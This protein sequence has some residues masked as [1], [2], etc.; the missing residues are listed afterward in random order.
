MRCGAPAERASQSRVASLALPIAVGLV[1]ESVLSLVALATLSRVS[2]AAVAAAGAVSYLFA[3]L[4]ALS[5]VFMNGVMVL[6]SQALGARREGVASRVIGETL[7]FSTA[8]SLLVVCSSPLWLEGY[9]WVVSRGN[10][11][12]V[13]VGLRYAAARIL[14][15]PAT[16]VGSVL[17]AAYRCGGRPWPAALSSVVSAAA[18][19]ILIPGLALGWAGLE[20]MG[21]LGAG[22]GASLASYVGLAS[23]ALFEPPIP[24]RPSIRPGRLALAAVATGSPLAAERLAASAAQNVYIN[25]VARGGTE[26]LAA[27]NIGVTVEMLIIQPSFAVGLATLIEAGRAVGAA[28]PESASRV[29]REGAKIG[30]AWMGAAAALLASLS[31]LV[32]GIFVDDPLVERLTMIYLL[33]AAASEVGLGLSSAIFGAI[34]GMGRVELP[35]LITIASVVLLRALPA[36]ILAASHG[37]PGAWATQITDCYGRALLGLAAWRLLGTGRLARKLVEGPGTPSP[38]S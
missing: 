30:V 35:T 2:V 6:A 10:S 17:S 26:A 3:L 16:M 13:D 28:S 38:P 25:A 5:Q 37:A 29:V 33:M 15:A 34:R 9:L 7:S 11:E 21:A 27:H 8:A 31:P 12:V 4:G 18:G 24:I 22:L 32:G 20:P 36:Q 23:Y 19:S 1:N 14:S